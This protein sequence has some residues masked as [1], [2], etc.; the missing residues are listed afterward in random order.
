[1]Q[2][3]AVFI[4][5]CEFVPAFVFGVWHYIV[6]NVTN[7][8]I[9]A[10]T[11]EVMLEKG[12]VKRAERRFTSDIGS[13]TIK[14]INTSITIPELE[15]VVVSDSPVKKP[16]SKK[17]RKKIERI[18]VEDAVKRI[19]EAVTQRV[20]NEYKGEFYKYVDNALD[21]YS[22][23]KTLLYAEIPREFETVYVPNDTKTPN[24]E[25]LG[26][27]RVI[28][29]DILSIRKGENLLLLL[30]GGKESIDADADSDEA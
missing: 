12:T 11:I 19:T 7:N 20:Y 26:V 16:K 25:F 17:V 3:I 30:G 27:D 14:Q 4:D 21:F 15:S 10:S 9:G 29:R 23:V 22:K 18:D 8:K 6:V 28:N 13:D 5:F 1:M 2:F 24:S